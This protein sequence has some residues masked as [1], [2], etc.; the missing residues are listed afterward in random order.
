[1]YSRR[2]NRTLFVLLSLLLAAGALVATIRAESS[3]KQRAYQ[4]YTTLVE[5]AA[6]NHSS[7]QAGGTIPDGRVIET[8]SN[9][10]HGSTLGLVYNPTAGHVRYA[11]EGQVTDPA[12]IWDIALLQPHGALGSV[13]LS[14]VNAGWPV[15]LN[16]RDGVGFD[17][18]TDTYF[19][20]DYQGDQTTRDDN[21]VEINAAGTILN[22]WEMDGASNDSSDGSLIN[23]IIDIAV[24]PGTPNRY[25]AAAAEGTG[26]LYEISLTRAGLFTPASWSTVS[27]CTVPGVGDVVGVD[28]NAQSGLL[29]VSSFS[30]EIIAITD[31]ACNIVFQF[32]C[33]GNGTMHTGVTAIEN[34]IP[35]EVWVTDFASNSTTRCEVPF[36]ILEKTVSNDGTCGTGD[37]LEVYPGTEITYCYELTNFS[38]AGHGIPVTYTTHS[39]EDDYLGTLLSSFPYTLTPGASVSVS[40]TV[41]IT[42]TTTNLATWTATS[43]LISS[44]S[45]DS[46]TVAVLNSPPTLCTTYNSTNVPVVIGP[47]PSVSTSTLVVGDSFTLFDVNVEISLTHTWDADLDISLISPAA[48]TIDLSSGNGGSGDNYLNTI[49]DTQAATPIVAGAPPYTG[50][51]QPE[52]SLNPLNG[53]PSAGTWTL[54]IEDT[55]AGD[56]GS[57]TAWSVELCEAPVGSLVMTQTVGTT[58]G[59]CPTTNTITVTTGTDVY[60]CYSVTNTGNYTLTHHDL[61]DTVVGTVLTDTAYALGPGV[62]VTTVDLGL[63]VSTNVTQTTTSNSTWLAETPGFVSANAQSSATVFTQP[64]TDVQLV[65]FRGSPRSPNWVLVSALLLFGLLVMGKVVRRKVTN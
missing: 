46:A 9:T 33:N 38:D 16:D 36:T 37:V 23:T 10:W 56:G 57:L 34:A 6:N 17:P 54:R 2:R 59:V 41:V 22:A 63:T 58:A 15:A 7:A 13:N 1:M 50:R 14:A 5:W 60:Y 43:G 35:P 55:A 29:Y 53:Q 62:T 18:A 64:P 26:L 40:K 47:D 51:F 65:E 27:T 12:T 45:T 30:N 31:L 61:L 21:I 11:H 49:F 52:Q 42:Q 48:A 19:L 44:V 32:V 39:L 8:F 4:V 3:G 28:Y 25:F 24:V 20:P